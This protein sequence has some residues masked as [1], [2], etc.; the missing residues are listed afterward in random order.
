MYDLHDRPHCDG[1]SVRI[2]ILPKKE[3]ENL[4]QSLINEIHTR[5]SDILIKNVKI[6]YQG[7]IPYLW[8][9]LEPEIA[10]VH[11]KIMTNL[12]KLVNTIKAVLWVYYGFD[13][14]EADEVRMTKLDIAQDLLGAFIPTWNTN[15][16]KAIK[17]RLQGAITMLFTSEPPNFLSLG[18]ISD[19]K[20]VRGQ[21]ILD[22]CYQYHVLNS[23]SK[24]VL[25]IKFYDKMMDLI[26]REDLHTIGSRTS[27]IV[28]AKGKHDRFDLKLKQAQ[29]FG[30]TRVEISI[31]EAAFNDYSPLDASVKTIFHK[32]IQ[33]ALAYIVSEVLNYKAI[34]EM[35]YRRMHVPRLLIGI[36]RCA[37]VSLL[38]GKENC[39]LINAKTHNPRRFVGSRLPIGLTSRA[40][41][42][43]AWTRIENF[44]KRYAPPGAIIRVYC[45]RAK[46]SVQGPV[47]T[48]RKNEHTAFQLPG[49]NHQNSNG[50]A[51][52]PWI[53]NQLDCY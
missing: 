28:G 20:V 22:T 15:T 2:P 48:L 40:K 41:N 47:T 7:E 19:L 9:T 12:K 4:K 26:S 18:R 24:K 6:T 45:L 13:D 51:T 43:A 30:M 33:T 29:Y 39:W 5:V 1:F 10:N 31:C 16:F 52:A 44:V 11:E 21:N 32:K 46:V 8:F 25:N 35:I 38:I 49:C 17:H 53:V 23:R 42:E 36:G 3:V 14:K 50:V 27:K 34:R 37:I